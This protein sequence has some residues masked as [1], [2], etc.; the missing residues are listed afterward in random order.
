M[1]NFLTPKVKSTTVAIT[2]EP[3]PNALSYSFRYRPKKDNKF[4]NLS[5][6]FVP[7]LINGACTRTKTQLL[8]ETE[9]IFELRAHFSS[10]DS[11]WF[12]TEI[13]TLVDTS[14]KY[15][16]CPPVKITKT[17]VGLDYVYLEWEPI[18]LEGVNVT[19]N[20]RSKRLDST[21]YFMETSN[22]NSYRRTL[23]KNE[24]WVVEVRGVGQTGN[25]GD[26]T[27]VEVKTD[28]DML[29]STREVREF[30]RDWDNNFEIGISDSSSK[31]LKFL[32]EDWDGRRGITKDDI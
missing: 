20:I 22:T 18:I 14:I 28:R 29:F 13:K 31:M 11:N 6:K 30:L 27:P 26:W 25:F 21:A 8:P 23:P 1:I 15:T 3:V 7:S 2:W 4:I 32:K 9:Y 24:N 10:S 16:P 19:Y 12:S 17:D 5:T